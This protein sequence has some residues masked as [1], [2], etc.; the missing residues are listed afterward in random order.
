MTLV[1]TTLGQCHRSIYVSLGAPY[2]SKKKMTTG[3]EL[4][5]FKYS[6]GLEVGAAK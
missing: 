1:S 6:R 2:P 3:D 4:P 5:C